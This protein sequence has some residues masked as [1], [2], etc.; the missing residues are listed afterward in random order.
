MGL[1]QRLR[2]RGVRVTEVS[3]TPVL[4]GR[5]AID[6]HVL[7]REHRLALPD[8]EGLLDELGTVRLRETRPGV[9]RLDHDSGSHDDRAVSLGLAALALMETPEVGRAFITVPRGSR[10]ATALGATGGTERRGLQPP[11]QWV[12]AEAARRSLRIPGAGIVGVPGD[13]RDPRRQRQW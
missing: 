4:V 7:L 5:L 9:F 10:P 11:L 3:F 2:A 12:I 6:L 1:A 8:D 13:C